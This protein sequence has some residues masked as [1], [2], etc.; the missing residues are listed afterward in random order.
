MIRF[1]VVSG[2]DL[3]IKS[4]GVSFKVASVLPSQVTKNLILTSGE[5]LGGQRLVVAIDDMF[6]Y[7][8]KDNA[9]HIDKVTGITTGAVSNGA[10]VTATIFG[11]MTDASWNWDVNKSIYLGNNGLLTQTVPSTGFILQVATVISATKIFVN[12]KPAINL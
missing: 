5:N 10:K 3:T 1:S 4:G 7:A 11:I 2:I 6:Y 8:D 12:L 9:T